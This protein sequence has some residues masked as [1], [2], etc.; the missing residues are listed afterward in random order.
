LVSLIILIII[1]TTPKGKTSDSVLMLLEI[2]HS[3]PVT[4]VYSKDLT[5]TVAYEQLSLTV[6]QDHVSQ[7][8]GTQASIDADEF[9][10]LS[11]PNFQG[12]RVQSN[13]A[14]QSGIEDDLKARLLISQ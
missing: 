4:D 10:V 12:V 11:V 13:D 3:C 5:S 6:V 9:A 7:L 8:V 2:F 14:K 1:V